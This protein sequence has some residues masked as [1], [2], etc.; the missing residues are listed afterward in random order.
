[1]IAGIQIWSG[2]GQ[3]RPGSPLAASRGGGRWD[4][5]LGSRSGL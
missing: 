1:M 5:W 4:L 3:A 2:W